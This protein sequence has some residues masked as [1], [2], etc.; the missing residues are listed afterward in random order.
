[1]RRHHGRR[2]RIFLGFLIAL[3]FVLSGAIGAVAYF[4]PA[5]VTAFQDTGH[6]IDRSLQ[7]PRHRHS[8][9]AA[10]SASAS[11]AASAPP[12]VAPPG[13]PFTVL[14]LGSDNDAKFGGIV[15][16]QSMILARVNPTTRQV[17]MESIPRDLWVPLSTGGSAK[18]DAA[19][20]HGGASAAVATVE[21]DFHIHIDHYAWI[22]LL[23]LVNLINQVGG[24]DVVATNPV[25]D[26][27]YPADLSGKNPYAYE[28]VAVLPGPQHMNG[29]QALMYVRSRH[30]DLR[31]DFGR[32]Q[33][34]QQVLLALRA[35]AKLLGIADLPDIATAMANDFSTDMS[36]GEIASLLPIASSVQLQNV[37]PGDPRVPVH[38]DGRA[39]QPG[40]AA[41]ELESHPPRDASVLP[42]GV[43]AN[44]ETR[45]H[46][47]VLLALMAGFGFGV[48]RLIASRKHTIPTEATV[49]IPTANAPKIV[50]PGTLYLA[51]NGDIY[52]LSD[53]FFTDLHLSTAIWTVDATRVRSQ[54]AGHRRG[55]A[56]RRV[57]EPLPAQQPGRDHPPAQ[58][59]RR[60]AHRPG[61]SQPL[62]VLSAH[63]RRRQHHLL[64]LRPAEGSATYAVDFSVWSGTLD[65]KLAAT[66]LSNS[67]PFTG[68]DVDPTPMANGD[69]IYSKYAIGSGN[70]Y[71]QI[72]IQ[73]KPH[74]QT[75]PAHDTHPGLRAAGAVTGRH[76]GRDDLHRRHRP[77]EHAPRG[78]D[79]ERREAGRRDWGAGN[80]GQQLPV[81][82]PGVGAGRQRARLLQHRRCHRALRAVV[83]QGRVGRHAV[84]ATTGDHKPRLRRNLA[85][86]LVA[87][88]QRPG[89]GPVA[90][91]ATGKEN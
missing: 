58:Q 21:E 43:R 55:A 42:R 69:V 65:G 36:I 75:D 78:R 19:Y 51:Q 17:V 1:M 50:L 13:Q 48:N 15:L 29:M 39:R 54:F 35:K 85:A 14:L 16:T 28:R 24:I 84:A 6:S 59:Q 34:Q 31:S 3:G 25:M 47:I 53:G 73:V 44:D 9:S 5:I 88:E 40:R 90:R 10:A 32:S 66:Q 91:A 86:E 4:M 38:V 68:G 20:L 49:F 30:G 87:A 67:N 81:R 71:S 2:S 18:I 37:Q 60:T 45:A 79:V 22:G 77:A 27:F 82:G 61:L 41:A 7:T 33:R 52:R 11:A 62:D 56:R 76:Q 83:D 8:A 80:A 74:G 23:G 64:Q 26:D 57:L 70:A 12:A 46:V 63:G 72:A 89:D